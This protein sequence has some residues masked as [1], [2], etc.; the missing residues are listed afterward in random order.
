M[1]TMSPESR[2][3]QD[4]FDEKEALQRQISEYVGAISIADITSPEDA[5]RL[6]LELAALRTSGAGYRRQVRTSSQTE[7]DIV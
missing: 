2:T 5:Y 4:S 1:L 6:R 7:A 3:P